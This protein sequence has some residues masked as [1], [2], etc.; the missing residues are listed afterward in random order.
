ME[1]KH[2][3]P[4]HAPRARK[5]SNRILTASL[6]GVLFFTLFP[7]WLDFSE[8]HAGSRSPF[9][10][11]GPLRFD[12]IL[13]TFL[14]TLLFA[15]FGFALSQFFGGRRK[16]LLKSLA[17]AVIAG[18]ALS[19]TIEILQLYMPS[20]DSAWDD[21]LANTLGA[22]VGMIFGL[23][24]GEFILDKLSEY[25]RQLE[26]FLSLR[27]IAIAALIYFSAWLVISIPLQQKTHLS[28]WDPNSFLI[29]G[30]DLKENTRWSGAVSRI[31]LWDR[32]LPADQ[33][34][35]LSRSADFSVQPNSSLLAVYDLSQPP[36]I[37]N[38][39][40]PLPNLA[41]RSVTAVPGRAHQLRTGGI[42]SVLMSESSLPALSSAVRHSNQFAAL[43]DCVPGR[44]NDTDGAIFAIANSE[45][46][47]DFFLRQE[48]S[49][50]VVFLRNGLE[51]RKSAL[52][53][54]VA[55]MFTANSRRSIVFSYDGAQASL[56]I[57][58]KKV[59][60]S[61][62]LSPGA[63]LVGE[64]IRIKTDELVAYSVLYNSLIFLP[65]GFL[66]GLAARIAPRKGKP[67]KLVL[68]VG[69]FLPAILLEG[70]L[71]WISGRQVSI[72]QLS[73]TISLTIA[74]MLWTNLDF[75]ASARPTPSP[76]QVYPPTAEGKISGTPAER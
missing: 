40:G 59:P 11:G 41:L 36:P 47:P 68:A 22:L 2:F 67:A 6:F 50:L 44:G 61:Y 58:G 29:V 15:P 19:Y 18:A 38:Q 57:D 17:V 49:S 62:Y 9:L 1:Q 72:F 39:T 23:V 24:S 37:M 60:K 64:L 4:P 32:A 30:V 20:R 66:L 21:V 25:E 76:A 12:G 5:W 56:Y 14:N 42:A 75:S 28:N 71:V 51:P 8:K 7:Y 55:G 74:G 33:A 3:D 34:N 26:Q 27:K 35:G 53:W 54:H 48:H 73:V 13:H 31:Q 52:T 45:G 46:A 10:L 16:S 70:L 43:V 69:I 63:G 65:L